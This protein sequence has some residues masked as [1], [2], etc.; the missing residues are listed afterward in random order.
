MN[1]FA[2]YFVAPTASTKTVTLTYRL[3]ASLAPEDYRLV[4]QR[5][6]GTPPLPLRVTVD[7]RQEEV[8]VTG[9][10]LEWV[11]DEVLR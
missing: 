8:I 5:Q 4:V 9:D 11:G 2:A 6:A 7:G 3:P 10:R 1:E